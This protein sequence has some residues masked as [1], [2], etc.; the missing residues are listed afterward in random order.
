M[1][2]C[3]AT[4]EGAASTPVPMEA[5]ISDSVAEGDHPPLRRESSIEDFLAKF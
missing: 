5:D 4:R 3:I 2:E 1:Y